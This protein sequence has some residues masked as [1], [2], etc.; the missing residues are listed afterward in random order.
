M[1][2]KL[3]MKKSASYRLVMCFAIFIIFNMIPYIYV[4]AGDINSNEQRVIGAASGT[5]E[6]NG[7]K[8]KADSSYVAELKSYLMNDDV[9]LTSEQANKAIAE[10]N[11]N[12][13]TGVS[14]GYLSLIT[15]ENV[16]NTN[17]LSEENTSEDTS[18]NTTQKNTEQSEQTTS[19]DIESTNTNSSETT[20]ED[21]MNSNKEKDS[22][23]NSDKSSDKK[24]VITSSI[25][26]QG[27]IKETGFS[28]E[29][30]RTTVI[31][32]SIVF[33]LSIF[34]AFR[35]YIIAQNDEKKI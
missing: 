29:S 28:I 10:I 27:A 2:D 30:A 34:A 19:N 8:Y 3:R 7:N 14:D 20:I 11:N 12:I 26:I 21:N 15:E 6:Y 13:Q 18:E 9:D 25:N 33:L 32:L 5:F 24:E 23:E 35:F 22:Y 17:A 16:D 4:Y 1:G 31:I